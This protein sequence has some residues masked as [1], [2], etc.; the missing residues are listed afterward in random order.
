MPFSMPSQKPNPTHPPPSDRFDP[1]RSNRAA[2][3]VGEA[4]P[5]VSPGAWKER[6]FVPRGTMPRPVVLAE[7][8]KCLA[9]LPEQAAADA[10]RRELKRDWLPLLQQVVEQVGG[11]GLDAYVAGLLGRSA[12]APREQAVAA[13]EQ[14]MR[15]LN[16]T[17][18]T[19]A[20]RSA[21]RELLEK[22]R[23]L[24]ADT[25]ARKLSL[26]RME[27]DLDGQLGVEAVLRTLFSTDEE[28]ALRQAQLDE[29]LESLRGQITAMPGQ[30]PDGMFSNFARLKA[31][32][33]VVVAE[34]KRRGGP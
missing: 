11:D 9:L 12:S 7:L 13:L 8:E 1:D 29:T 3:V 22:V 6:A 21:A 31:E 15:A 33:S 28:L 14:G 32:R 17:A 18:S 34:R 27:R 10:Q 24:L 19:E 30:K 4:A 16:Q 23:A 5:E 26:R 20:L 25:G 2:A